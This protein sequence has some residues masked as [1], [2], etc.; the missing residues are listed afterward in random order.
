MLVYT[1]GKIE[2]LIKLEFIRFC[3]VGGLGFVINLALLTLF[4]SIIGWPVFISQLISA[5]IAL[6][7]NFMLHHHWTYKNNNVKKPLP[8]LLI[9][10]HVTSWPAI[11]GSAL[12]VATAE[13]YLH[14]SNLM[15]LVTSSAIALMWNFGWTKY[16]IWRKVTELEIKEIA[17]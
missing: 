15:A 17:R 11:L 5:E 1:K 8:K 14:F 6:F 9:Q 3:I 16:V 12:M 4:H 7:S 2:Y 10:F 13:R